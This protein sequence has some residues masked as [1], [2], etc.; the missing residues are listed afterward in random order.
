[1][2]HDALSPLN[3]INGCLHIT[4][5][6]LFESHH[7]KVEIRNT[8]FLP[9]FAHPTSQS[10]CLHDFQICVNV[11]ASPTSY[12]IISGFQW[13]SNGMLLSVRGPL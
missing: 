5:H 4:P 3:F 13:R 11:V 10:L 1:M 8:L 9:D 7:P 2:I 12:P 6:S